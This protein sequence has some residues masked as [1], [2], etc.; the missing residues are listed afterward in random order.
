M[1]ASEGAQP[2]DLHDLTA[3]EVEA[4]IN[5]A[6][7]LLGERIRAP[8]ET[9]RIR[10][11][12]SSGAFSFASKV[13]SFIANTT[14][15]FLRNLGGGASAPNVTASPSTSALL[16]SPTGDGK[17]NSVGAVFGQA[18]DTVEATRMGNLLVPTIIVQLMQA[19]RAKGLHHD[20]IF[21][22]AGNKRRVKQLRKHLDHNEAIPAE[23][24]AE[25]T[26][27]DYA[28]LLKEYLRCLPEPLI[29]ATLT[30]IYLAV[31]RLQD[32][33]D[34]QQ[35]VRSCGQDKGMGCGGQGQGVGWG[36]RVRKWAGQGKGWCG[37]TGRGQ[38]EGWCGRA[39]AGQGRVPMLTN[40]RP[41]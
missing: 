39:R 13:K 6:I 31:S 8:I 17:E 29:S 26:V 11:S 24:A 40:T 41:V 30:P 36:V 37:R 25:A 18:L 38:E 19:I 1:A 33:L 27:H 32:S 35:M 14:P 28:D 10:T 9:N 34:A 12:G 16:G 2:I 5:A 7:T 23:A 4:A 20:G 3:F 21:R 22:V 15:S